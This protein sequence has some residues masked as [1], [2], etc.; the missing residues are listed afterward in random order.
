MKYRRSLERRLRYR[1]ASEEQWQEWGWGLGVLLFALLVFSVNLDLP[2]LQ[3]MEDELARAAEAIASSPNFSLWGLLSPIGEQFSREK[4][5]LLSVLIAFT[6]GWGESNAA[7]MRWPVAGLGALSVW[8]LYRT[9][10]EIFPRR[11]SAILAAGIY[12]VL[13]P[14]IPLGRFALS[15]NLGGSL[16]IFTVWLA[17]RSRRDFRWTL[18]IGG[19][20]SLLFLTRG[21]LAIAAGGIVL[22]FLARDTPR[23]LRSPYLWAGIVLGSFPVTSWI[24]EW[25]SAEFFWSDRAVLDLGLPYEL[26]ILCFALPGL[27]LGIS[28]LSL[29]LSQ[30]NW[31]W[32][33]LTLI[34]FYGVLVV[35]PLLSFSVES[36]LLL[37]PPL[38]LAGGVKLDELLNLPRERQSLSGWYGLAIALAFAAMACSLGL[39]WLFPLYRASVLVFAAVALCLAMVALTV[40]Q[41]DR[42]SL[43]LL[44]WG[45]YVALFLFVATLPGQSIVLSKGGSLGRSSDVIE[46]HSTPLLLF[47]NIVNN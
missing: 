22:V 17:L 9:G 6:Y 11:R 1:A 25:G 4:S 45:M 46:T 21:W 13:S 42:Q 32:A 34:W 33:N 44:F 23:L 8:V 37:F 12:L 26:K 7:M 47:R 27:F 43:I 41:G 10:R 31:G 2:S 14:L 36:G 39:A 30:R 38:A 20:L 40:S 16:L 28:G 35:I 19:G 29:A 24:L 15:I 18:G 3:G 5:P